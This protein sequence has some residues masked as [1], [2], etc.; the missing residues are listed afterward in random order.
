[1]SFCSEPQKPLV[2]LIRDGATIYLLLWLY[3]HVEC[4]Q[5]RLSSISSAKGWPAH[6]C[7]FVQWAWTRSYPSVNQGIVQV[8]FVCIH[9][10]EPCLQGPRKLKITWSTLDSTLSCTWKMKLHIMLPVKSLAIPPCLTVWPEDVV[11]ISST[12]GKTKTK[13]TKQPNMY[14]KCFI[15]VTH[16]LFMRRGSWQR[17]TSCV[18][19]VSRHACC[20]N[21]SQNSLPK[22]LLMHIGCCTN[23]LRNG[24]IL[25]GCTRHGIMLER[26]S[27]SLSAYLSFRSVNEGSLWWNAET[28]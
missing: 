22:H 4:W 10:Q 15:L 13:E 2:Q 11:R 25:P 7:V 19:R 20:W 26:S 21:L 16:V 9:L 28:W 18:L 14:I 5:Q 6:F 17:W 1:M 3:K 27:S 24:N 23:M 8:S 12:K